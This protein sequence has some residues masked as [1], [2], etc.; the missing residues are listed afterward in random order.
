MCGVAG[1]RGLDA[2]L[3]LAVAE[4]HQRLLVEAQPRD[5]AFLGGAHQ[6]GIVDGPSARRCA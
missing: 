4:L 2:L 5:A 6:R 3:V 1:D